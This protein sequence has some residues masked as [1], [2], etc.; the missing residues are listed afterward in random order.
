MLKTID[1]R[2]TSMR[3]LLEAKF[4]V[5]STEIKSIK[6]DYA[7]TE[8]RMTA[9]DV[10]LRALELKVNT[11]ETKARLASGV[12]ALIASGASTLVVNL[13]LWLIQK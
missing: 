13:I 2:F 7:H 9:M 1:D 10:L 4:Q 6:D 5:V 11:I 8:A 12:I 3:E